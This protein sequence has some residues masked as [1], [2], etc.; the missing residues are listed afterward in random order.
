MQSRLQTANLKISF[1]PY[2]FL[3]PPKLHKVES[4]AEIY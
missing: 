2:N 3:F 4:N 1:F